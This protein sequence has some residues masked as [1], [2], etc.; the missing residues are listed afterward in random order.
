MQLP[1]CG[2]R[3]LLHRSN[4]HAKIAFAWASYSKA[5]SNTQHRDS[6]SSHTHTHTHT[7]IPELKHVLRV[8]SEVLHFGLEDKKPEVTIRTRGQSAFKTSKRN[9]N[10]RTSLVDRATKCL[11]TAD[12]WK[13]EN[14]QTYFKITIW[15]HEE[16]YIQL[17]INC[18]VSRSPSTKV[19]YTQR[20]QV[21]M[22]KIHNTIPHE[23]GLTSLAACRNHSLAESALVMVSWVVKVWNVQKKLQ[24]DSQYIQDD[25][26][27]SW[28]ISDVRN[29]TLCVQYSKIG[30]GLA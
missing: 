3:R 16:I 12:F 26:Y 10:R 8:D 17:T 6:A 30:L 13:S 1:V 7:Y 9:V 23:S 28:S 21:M 15:F 18:S 25:Y 24:V 22:L 5:G 4:D 29:K 20:E 27:K 2:S 11:A 19:L 14:V